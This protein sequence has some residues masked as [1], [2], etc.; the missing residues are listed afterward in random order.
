MAKSGKSTRMTVSTAA[1]VMAWSITRRRK[2]MG[3][4]LNAIALEFVSGIFISGNA[5]CRLASRNAPHHEPCQRVD[6]NGDEEQCQANL[7]QCRKIQ[8]AGRFGEFVGEYAG[9]GVSG[10]E[11]RFGN[12]R[13]V[14]DHHG[15]RHGF[16]EGAAQTQNDGAYDSS[17]CIAQH[18][19]KAKRAS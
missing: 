18:T 7:D 2:L 13:T 9:H 17:P 1:P 11:Q 4:T 6:H 19:H 10:S 12:F 3:G 16:A 5:S 8:I 15:Y 14:A